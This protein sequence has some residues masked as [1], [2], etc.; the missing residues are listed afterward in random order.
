MPLEFEDQFQ[1][2]RLHPVIE[3]AVVT[4]LLKATGQHMH[5]VAADKFFI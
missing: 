2:F 3:E 5:Q 4:D 1:V